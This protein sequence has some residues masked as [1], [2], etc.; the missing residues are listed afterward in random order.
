[1]GAGEGLGTHGPR[2]DLGGEAV[3]ERVRTRGQGQEATRCLVELQ[4]KH[5]RGVPLVGRGDEAALEVERMRPCST[6]RAAALRVARRM[7]HEVT[8]VH[9]ASDGSASVPWRAGKDG[10][11]EPFWRRLQGWAMASI[12]VVGG[13]AN[14]TDFRLLCGDGE[15]REEARRRIPVRVEGV[16]EETGGAEEEEAGHP[17]RRQATR[18]AL[19]AARSSKAGSSRES[20]P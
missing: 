13:R 1:M 16:E 18:E 12:A 10:T 14:Q 2:E 6:R 17:A 15:A 7:R 4:R 19:M 20:R 5:G 11:Y 3:R 9:P 8:T